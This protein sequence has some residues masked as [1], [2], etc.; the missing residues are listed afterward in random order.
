MPAADLNIHSSKTRVT[1][2]SSISDCGTSF[3][4][5]SALP[6][7]QTS[8]L[9]LWLQSFL[10]PWLRNEAVSQL[11]CSSSG[12]GEGLGGGGAGLLF[13]VGRALL[14]Q[15]SAVLLFM[16]TL[17][18]VCET[19]VGTVLGKVMHY[20]MVV[21]RGRRPQEGEGWFWL[22]YTFL[23]WSSAYV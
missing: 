23:L 1:G 12:E 16:V 19:L 3:V 13:L 2:Q 17:A 18:G 20:P 15:Q 22:G 10:L 6:R 7:T 9:L 11:L 8:G 21:G 5:C 14:P 4:P